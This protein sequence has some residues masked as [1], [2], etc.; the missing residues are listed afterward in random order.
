MKN[1]ANVIEVPIKNK[2][3]PVTKFGEDYEKETDTGEQ[4]RTLSVCK[5]EMM[6]KCEK[7]LTKKKGRM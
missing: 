3:P 1:G 5:I 4:R 6:Y 2:F 7:R